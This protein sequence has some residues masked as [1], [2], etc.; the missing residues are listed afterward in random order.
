MSETM[1]RTD[2]R[3]WL[4]NVRSGQP[5]ILDDEQGRRIATVE[6]TTATQIIVNGHRFRREDGFRKGDVWARAMLRE[7]TPEKIAAL[8]AEQKRIG[9]AKQM[10]HRNWRKLPLE[11]L[12]AV[13]AL[14]EK[15]QLST[16]D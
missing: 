2:P 14:L 15:M 5:I 10:E 12:E 7:A 11:V 1:E 6:R 16:E 13:A 8:K 4:K 3:A 9:L